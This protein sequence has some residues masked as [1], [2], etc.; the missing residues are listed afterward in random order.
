MNEYE[1]SLIQEDILEESIPFVF[2]PCEPERFGEL[3]FDIMSLYQKR[4]PRS[5]LTA[6]IKMLELLSLIFDQFEVRDTVTETTVNNLAAIVK[7]YIDTNFL[8]TI[9]LEGLQGQFYINKYTLIRNF[10]KMY[11]KSPIAYY[12][13]RRLDYAKEQLKSTN[14]SVSSIAAQMNFDGYSFNRF[15]RNST[16]V[17]PSEYR[18]MNEEQ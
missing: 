4:P 11:K 16:G 9:T 8:E 10:N 17:S 3:F 2:T 6:K 1:L 12:H 14:R 5:E 15:F 18:R 13:E 7:N